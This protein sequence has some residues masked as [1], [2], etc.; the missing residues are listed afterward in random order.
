MSQHGTIYVYTTPAYRATRW[1]GAKRGRGLVKVGFTTRD[2]H[3]RIREQIGASSPE[4]VP[5]ELLLTAPAETRRG[6]PISDKDVH[7]ILRN[8]GFRNVHHEWFECRPKD[9]RSALDD[10]GAQRGRGRSRAPMRPTAKRGRAGRRANPLVLLVIGG[11]VG[12]WAWS[13]PAQAIASF[14]NLAGLAKNLLT[15]AANRFLMSA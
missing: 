13:N 6:Q 10:L 9:V 15:A 7:R 11:L 12:W 2:A 5:Y 3:T 14:E 8:R 1:Q 4:K